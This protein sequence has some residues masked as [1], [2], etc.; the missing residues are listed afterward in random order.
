MSGQIGGLV[1]RRVPTYMPKKSGRFLLNM[2]L[3]AVDAQVGG[4]FC[5][6][7]SKRFQR[8]NSKSH[9]IFFLFQFEKYW[10]PPPSQTTRENTDAHT[11]IDSDSSRFYEGTAAHASQSPLCGLAA[12]LLPC[13]GRRNLR[14]NRNLA[15]RCHPSLR[16]RVWIYHPS[17]TTPVPSDW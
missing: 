2:H 7:F 12:D 6:F 5:L 15:D 14:P 8:P 1:V 10:T 13:K 9:H 4:F 3:S 17:S 11:V 16:T